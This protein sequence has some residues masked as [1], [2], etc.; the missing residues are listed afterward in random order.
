MSFF[1]SWTTLPLA[2]F[3]IGLLITGMFLHKQIQT[4]LSRQEMNSNV[5]ITQLRT[6]L[7]RLETEVIFL[8]KSLD[9]D[10]ER[11][12][13]LR[14]VRAAIRSTLPP[15]PFLPGCRKKP[16]AAEIDRISV[17]IV[18]ATERFDVPITLALA[19][20][21]Q[22]SAFC[23]N[24]VSPVGARGIMQLMPA[25][26]HEVAKELGTHL[27]IYK[28]EDNI[29]LGT[30]YLRNMLNEFEGNHDLAIRAYNTGPYNVKKV[31]AGSLSD[32]YPETKHY[33]ERVFAFKAK[34][35]STIF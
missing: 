3:V 9:H 30:L 10:L 6:I 27:K 21:R 26:A 4:Q 14:T 8:K 5:K 19:L 35:D 1:I 7:D 23:Q 24:A 18:R 22:E 32:Y 20:A 29:V 2:A 15:T 17:A 33:A 12:K 13:K 28:L 31:L 11:K 34:F 16:S 25:T